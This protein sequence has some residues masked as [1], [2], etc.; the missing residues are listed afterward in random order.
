MNISALT[1]SSVNLVQ[2]PSGFE[3][4]TGVMNGLPLAEN[5]PTNVATE[6]EQLVSQLDQLFG[7][8]KTL[9]TEQQKQVNRLFEQIDN[10]MQSNAAS[11]PTMQ[12]QQQL[13]RLFDD[14]DKIYEARSFESLSSQEQKMVDRLLDQL[15]VALA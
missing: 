2:Q 6:A 13:D 3:F 11:G 7:Y 12:Q 9:N 15:D 1:S 5:Q 4:P 8:R 14:I 10:I